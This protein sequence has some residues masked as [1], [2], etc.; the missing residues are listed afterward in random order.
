MITFANKMV[1]L[2]HLANNSTQTMLPVTK[3]MFQKSTI[4]S[5]C[6]QLEDVRI[7]SSITNC[8]H[9]IYTIKVETFETF[10]HQSQA[11][12]TPHGGPTCHAKSFDEKGMESHF[13]IDRKCFHPKVLFFFHQKFYHTHRCIF[14]S[15][16]RQD[17]A[18]WKQKERGSLILGDAAFL[19]VKER[20]SLITVPTTV[21]L[22][23]KRERMLFFWK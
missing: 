7:W 5:L 10:S 19:E 1:Y 2:M 22:E 6:Q 3:E 9:I 11:H 17:A 18:F 12:R 20:G 13:L 15:K 23:V 8:L 4:G 16:K 14:G 21:F